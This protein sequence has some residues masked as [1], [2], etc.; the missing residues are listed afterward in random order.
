MFYFQNL[1]EPPI[2]ELGT[3]HKIKDASFYFRLLRKVYM[4]GR[5]TFDISVALLDH[6]SK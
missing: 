1:H 5:G 4:S 3:H 6:I 2:P